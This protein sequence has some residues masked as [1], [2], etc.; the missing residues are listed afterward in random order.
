VYWVGLLLILV[1]AVQLHWLPPSG[2]GGLAFLVLPALTL[3]MRSVAVIAR[4]TRAA[5]Q[6]VLQADYIRSARAIGLGE[7]RVVLRHGLRNALLPV[8]T[9]VGSTDT[10]PNHAGQ[11]GVGRCVLTA[12]SKRPARRRGSILSQRRLRAHNLMPHGAKPTLVSRTTDAA[13]RAVLLL[14]ASAELPAGAP[15]GSTRPP[16]RWMDR[17]VFQGPDGKQLYGRN[18]DR[19]FIPAS[20]TKLVVSAVAAALLPPEWTVKTSVYANGPVRDGVVEGDLILYGRGDP[21]M[22]KRCYPWTPRPPAPATPTPSRAFANSPAS[23]A[24]AG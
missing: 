11:P 9:V 2:S 6:E 13:R 20:N 15:E 4:M 12:I 24:P 22:S 8:I 1:F 10:S 21:T 18:A 16:R 14:A 3:G 19:M 7:G 17:G 23:C 5:M